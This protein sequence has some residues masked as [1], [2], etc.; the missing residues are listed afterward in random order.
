MWIGAGGQVRFGVLL[1]LL[2]ILSVKGE[3]PFFF[4]S[5]RYRVQCGHQKTFEPD[6]VNEYARQG[7][8]DVIAHEDSLS[9]V[10]SPQNRFF[11]QRKKDNLPKPY[12]GAH[13]T[14][15][16]E[17]LY[18]VKITRN[19]L[20][21]LTKYAVIFSWSK[22]SNFCKTKGVKYSPGLRKGKFLCVELR[23]DLIDT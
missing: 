16:D 11:N 19:K 20:L 3:D 15:N 22:N 14:A 6:L 5:L 1:V 10:N 18:E 21:R 13:F 2:T 7:C 4:W 17:S 23:H 9:H 8:R 12:K